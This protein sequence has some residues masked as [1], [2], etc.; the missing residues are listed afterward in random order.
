M[1][2]FM[3]AFGA[4]R[5]SGSERDIEAAFATFTQRGAVGVPSKP[6]VPRP[7]RLK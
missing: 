1:I 6:S 5:T 3:S 4:K 7:S 2:C